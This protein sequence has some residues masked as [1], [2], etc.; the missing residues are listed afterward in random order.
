MLV[1]ITRLNITNTGYERS[2]K[3]EKIFINTEKIISI[4]NYDEV[5][6]FLLKEGSDLSEKSF[7]LLKISSGTRKEEDL[8]VLGSPEEVVSSFKTSPLAKKEM[9]FD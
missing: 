8:I 6:S 9:L 4:V 2:T 1:S 5:R 7:S 3:L